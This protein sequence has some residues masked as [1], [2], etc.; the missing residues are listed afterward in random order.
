MLVLYRLNVVTDNRNAKER[1]NVRRP[2]TQFCSTCKQVGVDGA[3]N[4]SVRRL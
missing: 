3:D 2:R 4:C 1:R